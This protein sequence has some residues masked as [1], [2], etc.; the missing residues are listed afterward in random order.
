[1]SRVEKKSSPLKLLFRGLWYNNEFVNL[2]NSTEYK[3]S[4]YIEDLA[5]S[6]SNKNAINLKEGNGVVQKVNG[7]KV[8]EKK[9]KNNIKE[10]QIIDID[11]ELSL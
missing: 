7:V 1:M 3:P 9:E 2:G 4:K 6:T 11:N 5:E 10:E 8:A